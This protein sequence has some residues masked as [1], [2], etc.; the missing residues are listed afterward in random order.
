MLETAKLLLDRGAD[1]NSHYWIEG[2][3]KFT[4]VTDAIGEGENGVK[5]WPPHQHAR[6][7]V[8]LLLEGGAADHME[9]RGCLHLCNTL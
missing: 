9:L 1:P 8:T 2:S 5:T 4:C 6:A 7:L 3:Y